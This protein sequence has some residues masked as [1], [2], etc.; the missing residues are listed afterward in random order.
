MKVLVIDAEFLECLTDEERSHHAAMVANG[1]VIDE[2]VEDGL[3]ASVSIEWKIE[4]RVAFGGLYMLKGGV[5]RVHKRRSAEFLGSIKK[6]SVKKAWNLAGSSR[7]HASR[8][9]NPHDGCAGKAMLPGKR[10]H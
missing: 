8:L 6:G 2:L 1:Y 9:Y 5:F 4:G 3:K 10:T 7:C